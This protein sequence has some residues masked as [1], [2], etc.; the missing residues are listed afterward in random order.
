MWYFN[1]KVTWREYGKCPGRGEAFLILLDIY[2]F[3]P[4]AAELGSALN[5]IGCRWN[6]LERLIDLICE[7]ALGTAEAV[8]K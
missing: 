7:L 5:L 6:I 4:V 2:V 1:C 3:L 8:S